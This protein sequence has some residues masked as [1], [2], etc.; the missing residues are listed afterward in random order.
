MSRLRLVPY[1][2]SNVFEEKPW[3]QS[4]GSEASLTPIRVLQRHFRARLV[5]ARVLARSSGFWFCSPVTPER[6]YRACEIV[7]QTSEVQSR[8][9][10]DANRGIPRDI[11]T[12]VCQ[13]PDYHAGNSQSVIM[14]ESAEQIGGETSNCSG[15]T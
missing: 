5:R 8:A 10:I 11:W 9:D 3:T 7:I 1:V 2:S 12:K 13:S 6:A 14:A 15:R 4:W